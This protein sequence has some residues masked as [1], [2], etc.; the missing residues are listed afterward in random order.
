MKESFEDSVCHLLNRF[1]A[2]GDSVTS[3]SFLFRVGKSTTSTIISECMEAI[4]DA[5]SPKVFTFNEEMFPAIAGAF[6][7]KWHMPNCIGAID[8]KHIQIQVSFKISPFFT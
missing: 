4:W 1:I 7:K 2:S 3:I 6:E 5:L 8:G